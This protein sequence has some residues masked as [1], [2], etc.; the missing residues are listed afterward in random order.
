MNKQI[1]QSQSP[2]T[3]NLANVDT[4]QFAQNDVVLKC[5]GTGIVLNVP[6]QSEINGTPNFYVSADPAGDVTV[7]LAGGDNIFIN[8]SAVDTFQVKKGQSSF[9]K[10]VGNGIWVLPAAG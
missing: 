4:A 1:I 9:F 5:S 10:P 3:L 8:G 7:N 6:A 2:Y